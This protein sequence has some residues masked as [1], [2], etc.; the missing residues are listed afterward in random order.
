[1][2]YHCP[3]CR[4][5]LTK[6]KFSH[7]VVARM[8]I[9]CPHCRNTIRH[10]FHRAEVMAVLLGF[11]SF[12]VA[13]ASA[14]R[15]Q[16]EGLMLVALGAAMAGALALPLLERTYLRSWPRYAAIAKDSQA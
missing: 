3:V 6:R 4:V 11:G 1:M 13:A 9:D 14:Y 10:N 7:A 8:E 16:S 2:D 15:L 12:V 5:I